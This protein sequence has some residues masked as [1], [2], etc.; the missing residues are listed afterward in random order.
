MIAAERGR[1]VPDPDEPFRQNSTKARTDESG[2]H[3]YTKPDE[4]R[5]VTANFNRAIIGTQR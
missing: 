2:V 1:S 3:G 5:W 4:L